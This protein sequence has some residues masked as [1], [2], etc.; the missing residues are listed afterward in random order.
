MTSDATDSAS[1]SP[2]SLDPEAL[3]GVRSSAHR[4][5]NLTDAFISR[6]HQNIVTLMPES[7]A[8]LAGNGW[9][10]CERMA[11]AVLWVAFTDQS[12]AVVADVLRQVGAAN[13]REGF[14]DG[15]YVGVA[16]AL[17]RAVRDLSERDW[18]TSMGSAWIGYFLWMRPHLLAGS[19]Q[20]AAGLE[21]RAQP[22][23]EAEVAAAPAPDSAPPAPRHVEPSMS[24]GQPRAMPVNGQVHGA[25]L[26]SAGEPLDDEDEDDQVGYGQIMVSMTLNSRRER[27]RHEG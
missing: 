21:P 3:H 11:R 22:G 14:A 25:D 1:I 12:P 27:L 6:L 4:L 26:E 2:L 10:F 13:W 8:A 5:T 18:F 15:E 20:A 23:P 7:A 24:N 9:P 17:V 19:R 16:H